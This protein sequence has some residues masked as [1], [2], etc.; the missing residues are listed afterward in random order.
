MCI[1]IG[2][3]APNSTSAKALLS[4]IFCPIRIHVRIFHIKAP[5]IRGVGAKLPIDKRRI[6]RAL[7]IATPFR[8]FPIKCRQI[9][10][11]FQTV[12]RFYKNISTD[13]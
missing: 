2:V 6:G 10:T 4:Q 5:L 11:I 8:T 1:I 12:L 9:H 3:T 7:Y 13:N